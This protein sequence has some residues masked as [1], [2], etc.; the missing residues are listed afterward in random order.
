MGTFSAFPAENEVIFPP[1]SMLR[2]INVDVRQST[3]TVEMETAEFTD[4][5]D[6]I[7]AQDWKSFEE[8]A[9]RH[10]EMVDTRTRKMSMIGSIAESI[11]RPLDSSGLIPNP[12]DV[13]MR[14]GAD[15]NE[16]HKQETPFTIIEKKHARTLGQDRHMYE[17]WLACL[18][19]HGA[20]PS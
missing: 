19:H 8:W 5:W 3:V 10:P 11:S 9:S 20:T 7:K 18:R 14:Y 1:H 15:I 4:V 6:L 12:F 16:F 2:V 13:C 17:E